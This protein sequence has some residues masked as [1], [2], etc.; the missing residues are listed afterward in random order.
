S[1][2]S[3]SYEHN[4]HPDNGFSAR[5]GER[6]MAGR[7]MVEFVQPPR[8]PNLPTTPCHDP[9]RSNR[10]ATYASDSGSPPILIL[11]DPRYPFS[12]HLPPIVQKR[13]KRPRGT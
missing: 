9:K 4:F 1:T 12:P 7:R 2:G 8:Q 11:A 5:S 6:S 10:S 3:F 13:V